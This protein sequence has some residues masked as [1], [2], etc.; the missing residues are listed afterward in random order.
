[1]SAICLFLRLGDP[2]PLSERF[3]NYPKLGW[4]RA[5]DQLLLFTINQ[6]DRNWPGLGVKWLII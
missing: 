1:M 5:H 6:A 4:A 3:A 2:K